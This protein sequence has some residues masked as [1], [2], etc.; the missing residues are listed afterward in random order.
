MMRSTLGCVRC[1]FAGAPA[2]ACRGRT[3]VLHPLSGDAG[4]THIPHSPGGRARPSTD[5]GSVARAAVRR[6]VVRVSPTSP[7]ARV[8]HAPAAAL[9]SRPSPPRTVDLQRCHRVRTGV[10][11]RERESLG[12]GEGAV[13]RQC[14]IECL[15]SGFTVKLSFAFL[16]SSSLS[17]PSSSVLRCA[18]GCDAL[19]CRAVAK[20]LAVAPSRPRYVSEPADSRSPPAPFT[21]Q[22]HPHLLRILLWAPLP[23]VR[24]CGRARE[25]IA[26]RFPP[27][28]SRQRR[29]ESLVRRRIRQRERGGLAP[30]PRPFARAARG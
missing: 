5:P 21:P 7:L 23:L 3:G 1:G 25:R 17:L 13:T 19:C 18:Q 15:L 27:N 11:E 22:H 14:G 9:A 29:G 16:F 20:T 8:G 10:V 30:P 4:G 2:D 12:P 26:R 24:R 6:G 28:G